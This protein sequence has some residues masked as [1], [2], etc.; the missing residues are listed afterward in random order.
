MDYKWPASLPLLYRDF[1][2]NFYID[3][4]NKTVRDTLLLTEYIACAI[5]DHIWLNDALHCIDGVN[6]W[7][8]EKPTDTES[9]MPAIQM[10]CKYLFEYE[11]YC[12]DLKAWAQKKG[13]YHEMELAVDCVLIIM[14]GV[15]IA[16]G[17]V[18]LD[19][20]DK[21]RFNTTAMWN[22]MELFDEIWYS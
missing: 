19:M 6:V 5:R 10:T 12:K 3:D 7:P 8:M 14:P 17:N 2:N 22:I 18:I 21:G 4:F 9:L 1:D 20:T 15:T 13:G 11:V 16:A